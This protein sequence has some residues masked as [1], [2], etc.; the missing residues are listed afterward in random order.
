MQFLADGGP[1]P[2]AGSRPLRP[3]A[4]PDLDDRSA[5]VAG[6]LNL[7]ADGTRSSA[8]QSLHSRPRAAR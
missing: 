1:W 6:P 5:A 3:A 8:K 7:R 4:L 2:S